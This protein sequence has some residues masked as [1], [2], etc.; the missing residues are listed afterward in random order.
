MSIILA[1][2]DAESTFPLFMRLSEKVVTG[3]VTEN[4]RFEVFFTNSLI[5]SITYGVLFGGP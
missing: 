1:L 3:L 5:R 4:L 2:D